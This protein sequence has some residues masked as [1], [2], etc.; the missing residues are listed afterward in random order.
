MTVE[1]VAGV[2]P[3]LDRD[4]AADRIVP[5]G[6]RRKGR[7]AMTATRIA[8]LAALLLLLG[9]CATAPHPTGAEDLVLPAALDRGFSDPARAAAGVATVVFGRPAGVAGR[10][11]LA[12][13]AAANLEW[14]AVAVPTDQRFIGMP[15][16]V[17]GQLAAGRAELRAALGIPAEARPAAVIGA[18]DAAAAALR[19][20]D[21]AAALA[22]LGAV[23]RPGGAEAALALLDALP[24]LP[25]AAE[26]AGATQ[27]GLTRMI[28]DRGF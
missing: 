5:W 6:R 15:P 17:A 26:A 28:T 16:A 13:E 2:P 9:A 21:R 23:T 24:L 11:D 22:A 14:L 3:G 20:Q 19:R 1:E 8:P 7:K 25:R 18:M 10:P 4:A 12:A 27:N